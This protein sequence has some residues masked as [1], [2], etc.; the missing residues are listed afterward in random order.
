MYFKDGDGLR[1]THSTVIHVM[2]GDLLELRC[3]MNCLDNANAGPFEGSPGE[4]YL[5]AVSNLSVHYTR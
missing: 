2:A 4:E 5:V 3:T 1:G